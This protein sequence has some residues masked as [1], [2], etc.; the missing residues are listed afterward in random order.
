MWILDISTL[1]P[2]SAVRSSRQ[3]DL[4][5]LAQR[6]LSLARGH[7]I[8]RQGPQPRPSAHNSS[9][10]LNLY[11]QRS[12][13]VRVAI[14]IMTRTS[15]QPRHASALTVQQQRSG[16]TIIHCDLKVRVCMHVCSMQALVHIMNHASLV[17]R[18]LRLRFF[19]PFPSSAAC[20]SGLVRFLSL[21]DL[22]S[23]PDFCLRAAT[24][25]SPA[26]CS[27]T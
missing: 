18:A 14:G 9:R 24:T 2:A 26:S 25:S 5:R 11:A 21:S 15:S 13:S 7:V 6:Y 27:R 10:H 16:D 19:F 1:H 3:D 4:Q 12:T 22:A 17:A 23:P 8:S 20:S